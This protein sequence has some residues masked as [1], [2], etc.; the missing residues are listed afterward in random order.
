[1]MKD[2]FDAEPD[3]DASAALRTALKKIAAARS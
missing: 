3:I 1:M 2:I